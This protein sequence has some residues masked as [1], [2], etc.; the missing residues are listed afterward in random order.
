MYLD[1]SGPNQHVVLLLPFE[2]N[3]ELVKALAY[4]SAVVWEAM[5]TGV[6]L[7]WIGE[8]DMMI[9]QRILV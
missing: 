2:L 3:G 6:T 4:T 1:I 8:E 5:Q 9:S 7:S